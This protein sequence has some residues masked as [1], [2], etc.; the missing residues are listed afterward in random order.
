VRIGKAGEEKGALMI[1][2]GYEGKAVKTVP[3]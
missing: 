1:S 3:F 2:R